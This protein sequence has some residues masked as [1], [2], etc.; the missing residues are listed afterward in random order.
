MKSFEQ[1]SWEEHSGFEE[2]ASTSCMDKKFKGEIRP[3]KKEN[4][5]IRLLKTITQWSF[6]VQDFV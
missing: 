3:I 1:F 4:Y 6:N 5:F 2:D